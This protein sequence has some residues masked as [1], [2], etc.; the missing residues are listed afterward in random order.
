MFE[1]CIFWHT[2]VLS[3]L[4][5]ITFLDTQCDDL[6][7]FYV[8][9]SRPSSAEE[10]HVPFTKAIRESRETVSVGHLVSCLMGNWIKVAQA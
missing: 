8:H 10:I 6:F 5:C 4:Y 3:T 7:I 1:C 2:A 9:T